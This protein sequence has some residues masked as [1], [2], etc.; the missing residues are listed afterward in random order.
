Y[1]FPAF[2][3][4]GYLYTIAGWDVYLME[5]VIASAA[6]ILFAYLNIRGTTLTGRIQFI[7]VICMIV[8]VA[9]L[10]IGA[11]FHPSTSFSNMQ[12]LFKPDVSIWSSIIVI[13]AIAPW[14]FVGFD[15]VPQAAEEFNF[16][17]KKAF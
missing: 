14:A 3:E 12:P 17:P 8:G 1:I 4:Q 7:F 16:P 6:L 11:I 2:A 9:F 15:S 5:I 13:V 10:C